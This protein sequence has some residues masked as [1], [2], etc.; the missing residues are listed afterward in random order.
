[1]V[2]RAA[3]ALIA[4]AEGNDADYA[5]AARNALKADGL[6]N[7]LS[8]YALDAQTALSF[9][10]RVVAPV[11]AARLHDGR[12]A[13]ARAF[14]E[15]HRDGMTATDADALD[16]KLNK[17]ESPPTIDSDH[18]ALVAGMVGLNPT[19]SALD[20]EAQAKL[21]IL[22][23][24]VNAAIALAEDGGKTLSPPD[25][26][27]LALDAAA[28]AVKKHPVF[29]LSNDVQRV[30]N[31]NPKAIKTPEPKTRPVSR[32][33]PIG[34]LFDRIT[35]EKYTSSTA[36]SADRQPGRSFDKL[37]LATTVNSVSH[38]LVRP[39]GYTRRVDG[40]LYVEVST[41]TGNRFVQDPDDLKLE[42]RQRKYLG[43]LD[44][45]RASTLCAGA[46]GAAYL[47]GA[48]EAGQN[49]A[50]ELGSATGQILDSI[51]STAA[52]SRNLRL[53]SFRSLPDDHI[54]AWLGKATSKN[55]GD[56]FFTANPQ[57]RNNVVVHHAV[58]QQVLDKFPGIITEDE[59]HSLE[60][61]RGIPKEI[62]SELH[63]S[64]IRKE[65]NKFYRPFSR[66][67]TKPTKEQLLQKA[68][69]IDRKYG[70]HF[71]PPIGDGN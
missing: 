23:A 44:E 5:G 58:E 21:G 63:L 27:Q 22:R 43:T 42:I 37:L 4:G 13:E 25:R 32:Q 45:L 12:V 68:A 24:H 35:P 18:F 51:G 10:Q 56:A 28:K 38:G 6:A 41:P 52:L 64:I 62:N 1:M 66:S 19:P 57:L 61:L 3:G 65:W 7:G 50:L 11:V 67:K 26:F 8:G 47:A 14:F 2:A 20:V 36:W 53:S 39:G 54:E 34:F 33:V 9:G 46:Y 15:N 48:D 40:R 17:V 70:H 59:L 29:G 71:N 31:I 49:R 60:N 55:Y 16:A 30:L 69:E